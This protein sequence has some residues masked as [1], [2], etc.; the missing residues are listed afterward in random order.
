MASSSNIGR[1]ERSKELYKALMNEDKERVLELCK[2]FEDGPFHVVTIHADTVLH[3][4]TYSMQADLVLQ[5]LEMVTN[6]QLDKLT[7]QNKIGNTILHEASTS[8]S[9]VEAAK[10]MLIKAP[11]LLYK[12]NQYDVTPLYRS[13]CYG[14]IEMFKFLHD[15]IQ[16]RKDITGEDVEADSEDYYQ[17]K[18]KT[19]ILHTAVV[20]ESFDLA[21]LIAKEY[22]FL[23]NRKDKDEMTALQL[24]ACN[25][26]AFES[27]G[28]GWA[29]HLVCS[30]AGY[31][32]VPLWQEK[33]KQNQRYESALSL[34]K[35]LIKK[36]TSWIA[37]KAVED[38]D[39]T[40]YHKYGGVD[41]FSSS[42]SPEQKIEKQATTP[43]FLATKF[44]CVE[45]VKEI[46]SEYPWAVEY[47]DHDGRTILHR[48]IKY[49]EMQILEIVAQMGVP[50]RR[51]VRKVDRYNNTIL[52]MVGEKTDDPVVPVVQSPAFQLQ[53]NL[54]LFERVREIC[55]SHLL[56]TINMNKKTAQQLFDA[57]NQ[58][59]REK[60]KEWLK[61]T[62]ENSSIVAILIAT[63]AFAA[64]Y[65]IPGGPNQSTG[66][67]I[68]LNQPFFVVFTMTDV[69]SLTFA[70]TSVII[71]LRILTSPF[72][73]NDFKQSLPQIL[74]LGVT[75]LI[76]SVSMMMFAFAATVILMIHTRGQWTKIALYT[77]SFL[78]VSIFALSYLPLYLSLMK[79]FKYSLKKVAMIFP[80]CTG[81]SVLSCVKS[82]LPKRSRPNK[83]E[84]PVSTCPPKSQACPNLVEMA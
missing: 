10:K 40:K 46:L 15:E 80:H 9:L 75:F 70:L 81:A 44:G 77:A 72:R 3:V 54:L 27:K 49:R 55:P 78:P 50:M 7:F 79:T 19:T 34:A 11:G 18:N 59:L 13:V 82:F 56:N 68:L 41:P 33:W 8:D 12:R 53:D 23:I 66:L 5:L 30:V 14:K 48:A 24:L 61:S 73:L 20:I 52:H 43:L 37:T 21:L 39:Q 36:D 28:G 35:F 4:A 69:L 57:E 83:I 32:G 62:A 29:K 71:F 17:Q 2:Q 51:L 45:I 31:W 74:M 22:E 76:L 1:D 67:P 60:A 16:T 38:W 47:I 84:T 63:V 64:A 65:T 25:S 6:D 26:S 58:D 42:S